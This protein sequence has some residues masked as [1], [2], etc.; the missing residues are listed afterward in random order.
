[1]RGQYH[2]VLAPSLTSGDTMR[3]WASRY[4]PLV[5]ERCGRNK[6]QASRVLDISC[7]TLNAYLRY[8]TYGSSEIL[9]CPGRAEESAGGISR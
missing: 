8:G 6:R 5:F 9:G 3:A 4:A 1:V 7:H 2:E